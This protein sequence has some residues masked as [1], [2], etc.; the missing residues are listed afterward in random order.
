M[1]TAKNKKKAAKNKRKVAKQRLTKATSNLSEYLEGTA[2][3]ERVVQG[4]IEEV[5]Q[6]LASYDEAQ[7]VVD[8]LTDDA[9]LEQEIEVSDSYRRGV[10]EAKWDAEKALSLRLKQPSTSNTVEVIEGSA[11]EGSNADSDAVPAPVPAPEPAPKTK[12]VQASGRVPTRSSK[13]KLPEVTLPTFSGDVTEFTAFWEQFSAHV[14]EVEDVAVVTKFSYLSSL[15]KGEAASCISGLS[16]TAA[17]YAVACNLLKIRFGRKERTIFVHLQSLLDMPAARETSSRSSDLWKLSDELQKHVR[18]LET[19]GVGGDQYGVVLTPLILSKLPESLRLEWARDGDGKESDLDYLL[20]F[21][22]KEVQCRE[23]SEAFTATNIKRTS[24]EEKKRPPTASALHSSTDARR[25]SCGMCGYNHRT[26]KCRQLTQASRE[27]RRGRVR[28]AG[29]CFACLGE[30]HRASDCDKRCPDCH[31]RHHRLLCDASE[32]P[33]N[34]ASADQPRPTNPQQP[35]LNHVNTA[36][37]SPDVPTPINASLQTAVVTVIDASGRHVKATALLDSG[38]DR[39]YVTHAFVSKVTPRFVGRQRLNYAPFGSGKPTPLDCSL[40]DV[41][42]MLTDDNDVARPCTMS[43][44]EVPRIC[45]PIR[46]QAIPPD[47][48]QKLKSLPMSD[49]FGDDRQLVIDLLIGLDHYWEIVTGKCIR[50]SPGLVAQESRLGWIISGSFPSR[51]KQVSDPASCLS[52]LCVNGPSDSLVRSM[53][54]L[55]GI[56]I[57]P[58]EMSEMSRNQDQEVLGEFRRK[59][60]YDGER[61]EVALPWNEKVGKLRNNRSAAAA[62]LTTLNRKLL[63]DPSLNSEYKQA[64]GEFESSGIVERVPDPEIEPPSGPIFYLP[65][66]PVVKQASTSTKVRPVFDASARGPNGISLNDCLHVGPC[67]LPSL[68][69]V[70]LRFRRHAVALTADIRKAFLQIK[71]FPEDRDAHRYLISD[72]GG[73]VRELRFERV[74]FGNKASPF[75]LNATVQYHLSLQPPSPAVSELQENLYVDDWLSGADSA[76]EAALMFNDARDVMASAGMELVKWSSN[77]H[78]LLH[79]ISQSTGENLLSASEAVLGIRW[80][81]NSDSFGFNAGISVPID[82]CPTKRIVLSCIARFFD[83]LGFATPYVMDAKIL[84]QGIWRMGLGW[85]EALPPEQADQFAAWITGLRTLQSWRVPR[86]LTI[87]GW[88]QLEGV[89][90]HAFSDASQ[91]AYGAAVY[92]RVVGKDATDTHARL[93]MSRARVAPLK[94]VT[95]PR[96]ELLAALL[97]SRLIVSVQ[98]AL[99]L[100]ASTALFCWTDSMVALGWLKGD[101]SRWKT[102]VANRVY[103]IHAL[104]DPSCRRHVPGSINPADLLTRGLSAPALVRDP[105]WIEGPDFDAIMTHESPVDASAVVHTLP[106]LCLVSASEPH[107]NVQVIDMD[108]FS[109]Y[110]KLSRALAWALRFISNCRSAVRSRHRGELEA[111]ELRASERMLIKQSQSAAFSEDIHRLSNGL[112]VSRRSSLLSLS[113]FIDD[114]GL[115]RKKTRLQESH[116]TYD[117][118]HPIIL[119]RDRLSL[120]LVRSH[121][122]ASKHAGVG[123]LMARIQASHWIVGLRCLAKRVKHECVYCRRYD[124]RHCDQMPAP[125]PAARVQQSPPF[126]VVGLDYAGPLYCADQPGAK[127]Y[128]L[129]ITCAVVRAV[130]LEL[131]SSLSLDD[132]LLAFRRFCSRRGLPSVVYSDNAR[133][134]KGAAARLSTWFPNATPQWR[135]N[136]PAAPWWGGW[137]ER[138]VGSMKSC[139]RKSLGRST[140]SRVELETLLVEIEGC[141]N[142]RPLTNFDPNEPEN[143][144]TPNHFLVGKMMHEKS[145]VDDFEAPMSASDLSDAHDARTTALNRFWDIWSTHYLKSLRPLVSR[146]RSRGAPPVGSVVMIRDDNLPRLQWPLGVIEENYRGRDGLIRAMKVRTSNGSFTRPI[147]RLYDLEVTSTDVNNGRPHRVHRIPERYVQEG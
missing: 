129:L 141:I 49:R 102:F 10:L 33:G 62:R 139:I 72:E 106:E 73:K 117:A 144:L 104:L 90:L 113:P 50:L 123:A 87:H 39:S 91:S 31:R 41:T 23:R 47:E 60:R 4:L 82:V 64:L 101:P 51:D 137:W 108:R 99:H 134:F 111:N 128:V 76:E 70:L 36:P 97:A 107:E 40:F 83:P 20:A 5:N 46:R 44:C 37:S 95:L 109:T 84:F 65:H 105:R 43:F 93:V 57:S 56:G 132:F 75:L 96:L 2:V 59:I 22:L 125:L 63:R 52:L 122:F 38:A 85:D 80:D 54:D 18:C 77:A 116:L 147:Q 142:S 66:R 68:V 32:N 25:A 138:L 120:L 131:T 9:D 71:V 81:P 121:H 7:E 58:K 86:R 29:L 14:D 135:F 127:F 89:E 13:A 136:P 19:L 34:G 15:L 112:P 118:K 78:S 24:K 126:T 35:S 143:L 100:P 119:P 3:E 145:H 140:I 79:M 11:A 110:Q 12:E 17:N 98:Q 103:E 88:S 21:L 130:H 45:A 53:W 55:D 30:G 69:N 74:P 61:Y 115:M 94:V 114:D 133:T 28:N 27:D 1:E 6:R 42:C 16:L 8:L 26:E 124:A 67:L 92:L 146:F 48:L